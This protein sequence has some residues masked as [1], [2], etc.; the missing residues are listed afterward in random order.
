MR[1]S[2]LIIK[3]DDFFLHTR[4][5]SSDTRSVGA[6]YVVHYFQRIVWTLYQLYSV[7]YDG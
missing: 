4:P 7:V 5:I 6:S 1:N 2:I 3:T